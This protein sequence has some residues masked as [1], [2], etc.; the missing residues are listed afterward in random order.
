MRLWCSAVLGLGLGS[1]GMLLLHDIVFKIPYRRARAWSSARASKGILH[2][3]HDSDP[4]FIY[5][6]P[7]HCSWCLLLCFSPY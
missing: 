2:I 7:H 1:S 4:S 3:I 5:F 6:A